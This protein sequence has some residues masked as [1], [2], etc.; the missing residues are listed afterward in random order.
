[1]KITKGG[2]RERG[3]RRCE[4]GRE[5][6]AGK[7]KPRAEAAEGDDGLRMMRR[8]GRGSHTEDE[9]GRR[10][11]NGERKI[12]DERWHRRRGRQGQASNGKRSRNEREK[13]SDE[14]KRKREKVCIRQRTR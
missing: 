5:D 3:R 6:L 12:K 2:K 8:G 14:R 4:A 13:C 1:M 11:L 10:T 9:G 7:R